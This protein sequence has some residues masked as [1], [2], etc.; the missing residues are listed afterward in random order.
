M[1]NIKYYNEYLDDETA[2]KESIKY[3]TDNDFCVFND[4][5]RPINSGHGYAI[6]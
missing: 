4:T 2:I 3:T 5:V 1:A 6:K